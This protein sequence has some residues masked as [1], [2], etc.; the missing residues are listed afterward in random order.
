LCDEVT[1]SVR[2]FL[3]NIIFFF[4][5]YTI[6]THAYIPIFLIPHSYTRECAS[7]RRGT[8]HWI[9]VLTSLFQKKS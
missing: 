4:C 2:F 8:N 5:D 9:F 3:R 6:D 1:R 7:A